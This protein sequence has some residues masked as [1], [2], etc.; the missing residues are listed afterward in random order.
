LKIG[1]L[2]PGHPPEALAREMGGYDAMF[3]ALLGGQG[4]D[5]ATWDVEAMELPASPHDADAW[6]VG[7][8]RHAVY[9][10]HP[11]LPPLL[12][13][14][15]AAWGA[16]RRIVG[17]CFGHQA[18]AQA[19]GGHVEKAATGWE[20]GPRDYAGPAGR[21]RLAAWHQD[22]IARLPEAEV[23]VLAR[24][25]AC[26]YAILRYG[27]RALTMQPHPEL[28]GAVVERLVALRRGT[29]PYPD[30][31]MDAAASAARGTELDQAQAARAIGAFLR[32][33][34]PAGLTRQAEAADAR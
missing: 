24:T 23:E 31:L 32:E 22:Q 33:G 7:G 3:R 16:R 21:L 6:L 15:R 13:F 30:A 18:L 11:F 12:A 34:V 5:F 2:T 26:P 14:L 10:D 1:I 27:D 29:P 17:I 19:L 20:L 9:E 25:P 4:F 8:S 28:S